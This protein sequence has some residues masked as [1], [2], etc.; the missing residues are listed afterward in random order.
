[1]LAAD[2]R[3]G[4]IPTL[5]NTDGRGDALDFPGEAR[6]TEYGRQAK[7][8]KQEATQAPPGVRHI[9]P[10]CAPHMKVGMGKIGLLD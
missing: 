1:M 3:F 2:Q 10:F 7:P 5:L 6:L 4:V 9:L 8:M